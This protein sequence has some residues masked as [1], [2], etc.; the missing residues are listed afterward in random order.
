MQVMDDNWAEGKAYDLYMGRWSQAAAKIFLHWLNPGPHLSWLDVGCGTGALSRA[1]IQFTQPKKVVG[2]DPVEAFISY[3]RTQMVDSR[4]LFQKAMIEDL[5]QV[6]DGFEVVVSGL[7]LNFITDPVEAVRLMME[8]CSPEGVVAAFVWDYAGRM[9]FLRT[10]WDAAISLDE[11]ATLVEEG[12]R[13]P[14]CQPEALES[15][16]LEAGLNKVK[17]G[18]IEIKTE[19]ITF[20]DFW[21]PFLAGT[22]PAPKYVASLPASQRDQ[23]AEILKKRIEPAEGGPIKMTARAWAVRGDLG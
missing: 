20:S 1:I 4:L 14:L 3:A 19:F 6:P 13:F 15:T 22:G 7:V 21:E 2:C 12:R 18:S 23:L 11:A 5:P 10:F 16:F 8:R 9:D 17:T